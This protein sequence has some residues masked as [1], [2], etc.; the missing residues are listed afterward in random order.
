MADPL[1]WLSAPGAAAPKK[2][3]KQPD[4]WKNVLGQSAKI[5]TSP[6]SGIDAVLGTGERAVQ[7]A[8]GTEGGIGQKAG[9]AVYGAFHPNDANFDQKTLSKIAPKLAKNPLGSFLAKTALDPLMYLPI[10][11]EA[12]LGER[13][14]L[15][16]VK[17][18]RKLAPDVT[19][20]AAKVFQP[21]EREGGGKGVGQHMSDLYRAGLFT[22]P[23]PHMLNVGRL[24][25]YAGG[26]ETV[27]RGLKYVAKGIPEDV[28]GRLAE[29]VGIPDYLKG[30]ELNAS[31]KVMNK[32]DPSR[33]IPGMGGQGAVEKLR[34][35][36][37][38]GLS[39]FDASMR[40]S[41]LRS[42][43]K[44]GKP[45]SAA[46]FK[47]EIGTAMGEYDKSPGYVETLRK[48]GG[49]FPQWRTYIVPKAM[50]RAT[51]RRPDRVES[52]ARAV[53]TAR[54]SF[55]VEFGGPEEDFGKAL[56]FPT[57]TARYLTSPSTLGPFGSYI[58][59]AR[60]TGKA[61]NPIDTLKEY[62]M[63]MI[64]FGGMAEQALG[65]SPYQKPPADNAKSIGLGLFGGYTT[66]KPKAK[67]QKA[68]PLDWLSSP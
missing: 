41:L 16:G 62:G 5:A 64:P 45:R 30:G 61:P 29:H 51:L 22:N 2:A 44:E 48:F 23:L 9:G 58:S 12:R 21:I 65:I 19:Y 32:M 49:Y 13:A 14:A 10:A 35:V 40:A 53:D 57:G 54:N 59:K 67:K 42:L 6:L 43:E 31:E 8:L 50:G 55:G 52:Y 1:D 46:Q 66:N 27:G 15:A 28:K 24:A 37:Q 7:G 17:A 34:N 25:Y 18:A 20:G 11:G 68:H 33:F 56:D 4:W 63:G 38:K 60:E 36:G 26:P 39:H 3:K 47:G